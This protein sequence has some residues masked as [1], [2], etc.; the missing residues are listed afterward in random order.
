[1]N[2]TR[3]PSTT[4]LGRISGSRILVID[5]HENIRISLK[6]A[7]ESEGAQIAE[8]GTLEIAKRMLAT[9]LRDAVEKFP[10]HVILLDIRLPDGSGMELLDLLSA[11][12]LA[13]RVI[14]ISG[15]GTVSEAFR[16]TQL[17]A[18]DFVE[19]PF[20]SERILVSV[21]R[22]LAFNRIH[23]RNLDLESK[24]EEH[25]EI[26]GHSDAVVELIKLIERVA[27]TNGRVL[28]TG[29]SGTGKELVARAIHHSSLR[30]DQALVKVNCAAIPQT[31]I[32][33]ELFGHEKGAFTGALK[34]HRGVFER[35]DGGTLFLDE[36]GELNLEVQAKLLRVLQSGELNRVG[37]EAALTV[38][39]RLIAATNRDLQDLVAAGTFREDLYYRLNV[40]NIR[41]PSLRERREDIPE[42]ARRFLDEAC[43]EN[44]VG[45]RVFS[46]SALQQLVDYDWPGNVRE[47]KNFVERIAILSES[48]VIEKLD[49]LSLSNRGR[50]IESG[51]QAVTGQATSGE[52]AGE[53][54]EFSSKVQSWQAFHEDIGRSYLM[55]VLHSTGGNVS[56]A[57]RVLCLERA[58]LHRLMRKLGIQRDVVVLG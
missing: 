35:A 26:V 58:Y 43:E 5:D 28:I 11:A 41:V 34:V 4:Q 21:A 23:E 30:D 18:F 7:L 31:L 36:I 19:K 1:M 38:D 27:P 20:T 57:A 55:Y 2:Q 10:F 24:L 39:V 32:E 37:S 40:V 46:E 33:S 16:A 49:G 29:E 45:Y 56:E 52:Q 48:S 51:E 13:T 47:L 53:L 42:L 17:G 50:K 12:K 15:E 22:C 25:S 44:S 9:S 6:V 3:N 8:A 14:M 54:F